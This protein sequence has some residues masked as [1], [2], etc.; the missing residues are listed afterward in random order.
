MTVV[1]V[2][3]PAVELELLRE[4]TGG[5]LRWGITD[6]HGAA[7]IN[8]GLAQRRAGEVRA[9]TLGHA[10]LALETTRASWLDGPA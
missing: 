4:L 3:L 10:A 7:L 9:T 5:V 2:T 1:G 8:R 6:Q